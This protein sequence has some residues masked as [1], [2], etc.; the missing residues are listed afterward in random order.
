MENKVVRQELIVFYNQPIPLADNT[1][2]LVSLPD[3]EEAT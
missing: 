3:G 1:D 2:T